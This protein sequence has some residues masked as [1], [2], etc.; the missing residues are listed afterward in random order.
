MARFFRIRETGEVYTEYRYPDGF[1]RLGNPA[2]GKKKHHKKNIVAVPTLEEVDDLLARG[3][4]LRM[5]GR[6]TQQVNM[7]APQ[8]IEKRYRP[9][10]G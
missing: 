7:I 5:I 2:C 10:A 4:S 3:Y 9:A 1:F 6:D 8:N